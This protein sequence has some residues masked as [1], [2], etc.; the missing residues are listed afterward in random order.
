LIKLYESENRAIEEVKKEPITNKEFYER[1][2]KIKL[3]TKKGIKILEE[4]IDKRFNERYIEL[5]DNLKVNDAV[6]HTKGF[7]KKYF[8]DIQKFKYLIFNEIDK[9]RRLNNLSALILGLKELSKKT[10]DEDVGFVA[11]T[12]AHGAEGESSDSDVV[13]LFVIHACK[14]VA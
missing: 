2:R 10:Y 7:E 14:L 13:N 12:I 4:S 1:E 6:I 11:E 3:L 9:I 5:C 8:E